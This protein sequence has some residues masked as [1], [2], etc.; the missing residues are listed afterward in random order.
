[1][2]DLDGGTVLA[3]V[4][5]F[6]GDEEGVEVAFHRCADWELEIGSWRLGV[7]DWELEIGDWRLE[8]GDW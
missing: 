4:S 2:T 5:A 8:I 6:E 3:Q 7:G 1:M